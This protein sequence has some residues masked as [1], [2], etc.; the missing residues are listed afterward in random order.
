MIYY[1]KSKYGL[2]SIRP[3]P[4]ADRVQ[5]FLNEEILGSYVNAASAAE[6]VYIQ[7]TGYFEWDYQTDVGRPIT[8][9]DWHKR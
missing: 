8:L 6:D 7:E 5:L 2:F 3:Q 4:G 1:F 9:A